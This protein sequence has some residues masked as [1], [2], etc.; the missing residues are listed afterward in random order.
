M[1][2]TRIVDYYHDNA[3]QPAD[4]V[5]VVYARARSPAAVRRVW[6]RDPVDRP[7][8]DKTGCGY[9]TG[10]GHR[11]GRFEISEYRVLLTHQ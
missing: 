6:R 2:P 7:S 8:G 9:D 11:R 3:T 4:R 1:A 10:R 5:R